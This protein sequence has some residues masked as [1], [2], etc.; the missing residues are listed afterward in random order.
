[1]LVGISLLESLVRVM[2][3]VS[4]DFDSSPFFNPNLFI[5]FAIRRSFS[6]TV[7]VNF[8]IARDIA[9]NCSSSEM[10]LVII[11]GKSKRL[12]A[13]EIVSASSPTAVLVCLEYYLLQLDPNYWPLY[14]VFLIQA[15][16]ENM[17]CTQVSSLA[18]TTAEARRKKNE[19]RIG[20][21]SGKAIFGPPLEEYWKKKLQEEAAAK[22]NDASST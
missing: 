13:R 4:P 16:K 3:S 21:V 19:E 17:P 9:V 15:V 2:S 10:A 18:L 7:F 5:K 14:N 1:M 20:V 22:E 12:I 11:T 8:S 6:S